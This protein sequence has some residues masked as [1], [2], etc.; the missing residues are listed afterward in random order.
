MIKMEWKFYHL[1]V[2]DNRSKFLSDFISPELHFFSHVI[3]VQ[4]H[5]LPILTKIT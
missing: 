3:D 4:S 5:K 1:V 2:L